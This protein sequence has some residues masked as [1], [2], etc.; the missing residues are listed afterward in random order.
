[1]LVAFVVDEGNYAD[2]LCILWYLNSNVLEWAFQ[3]RDDLVKNW[4]LCEIRKTPQ[5]I[6][7][8]E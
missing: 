3:H 2:N 4:K 8:L 7:P 6:P 1:M 5:K